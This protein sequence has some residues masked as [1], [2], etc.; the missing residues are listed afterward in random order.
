MKTPMPTDENRM[1][2]QPDRIIQHQSR[3][4]ALQSAAA[5]SV[6]SLAWPFF[7]IQNR[8]ISWQETTLVIGL[9]AL[10]AATITK[11]PWWWKSMHALFAPLAY[12]VTLLSINPNWYLA[13]AI[14]V[15][16]VYRGAISGRIPLYLTNTA[17]SQTIAQITNGY[18]PLRFADLGAGFGGLASFMSTNRPDALIAGVE[19][20]PATWLVGFMRTFFLRNCLWHYQSLWST[21]LADYDVVYAFLSPVPMA[22][23]WQKA[24]LEMPTG[25][26]FISNSFPVPEVE[27]TRIVE[28][29]DQRQTKLYCYQL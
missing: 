17:T 26:L 1:P 10:I 23:L 29:G 21:N 19:N 13:A 15:F 4:L 5:L 28:V 6:L 18:S 2:K 9:V 27:P 8:P 14:A 24:R 16:L 25:T 3:Q 12:K 7:S 22:D 11:Q 20:A